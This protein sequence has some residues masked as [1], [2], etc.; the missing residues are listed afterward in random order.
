MIQQNQMPAELTPQDAQGLIALAQ[1]AP[2]QNLNHARAVDQLCIRA[3]AHFA[4]HFGL[5]Q[6]EAQIATGGKKGG[7]KRGEDATQ[8]GD[9]AASDPAS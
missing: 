9:G 2:L 8:S 5:K 1:S 6:A 7:K 3:Q 4:L